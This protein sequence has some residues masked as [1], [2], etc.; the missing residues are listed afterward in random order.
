MVKFKYKAIK[1]LKRASI[2]QI[3]ENI[4][5]KKGI[6]KGGLQKSINLYVFYKNKK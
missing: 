4:A 5:P 1:M 2:T 3:Y 6:V